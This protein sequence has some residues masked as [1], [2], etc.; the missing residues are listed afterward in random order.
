MAAAVYSFPQ[1]SELVS[2]P[3][4]LLP[5]ASAIIFCMHYSGD[6]IGYMNLPEV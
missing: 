5:E 2:C 3:M 6:V 1:V 4:K